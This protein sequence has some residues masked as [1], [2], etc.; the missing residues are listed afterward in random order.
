VLELGD[1]AATSFYSNIS[2]CLADDTKALKDA[3]LNLAPALLNLAG[4][5]ESDI[6]TATSIFGS[7]TSQIP[8]AISTAESA[9]NSFVSDVTS[10]VAPVITSATAI[11]G[12]LISD[13]APIASNIGNGINSII[14]EIPN[15]FS[16]RSSSLSK[17]EDVVSNLS[18]LATCLSTAAKSNPLFK[19]ADCASE[20]ASVAIPAASFLRVKKAVAVAG[21]EG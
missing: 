17:I 18:N 9:V 11:V 16:K 15:P 14:G 12:S 10:A 2:A 21:G 6:A 13:A 3:A 8:G 19:V 20:I 4:N 7:L 5:I 1:Q